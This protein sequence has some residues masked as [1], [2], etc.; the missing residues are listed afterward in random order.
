MIVSGMMKQYAQWILPLCLGQALSLCITGTST[1]S[2]ALWN[3]Y[4]L[5][6]PFTQNFLTYTLLFIVYG[7][8]KKDVSRGLFDKRT[9]PCTSHFRFIHVMFITS[10]FS[11]PR[12]FLCR[13][14]RCDTTQRASNSMLTVCMG[15]QLTCW[16]CWLSSRPQ[17]CLPSLCPR[18]R[19]P[20]SCSFPSIAWVTVTM[21]RIM[22]ASA[23]PLWA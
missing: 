15:D 11:S 19:C 21:S 12:L 1:A 10:C 8:R 6:M 16:P 20:A 9:W 22:V 5:N 14:T 18:G 17:F 7:L 23:Y 2:S 13:C 4:S 3:H